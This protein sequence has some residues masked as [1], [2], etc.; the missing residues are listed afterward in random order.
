MKNRDSQL[1]RVLEVYEATVWRF[2]ERSRRLWAAAE[3]RALGYGGVTLVREAT[4]FSRTTITQGLHE[5][6]ELAED[7]SG[8]AFW[9]GRIR[10][11]GSGRKRATEH[12]PTLLE[13]LEKLVDPLTRGDPESALRWTSKSHERLAEELRAMGHCNH[14]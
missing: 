6:D 1:R 10:A 12:D 13:D 9:K 8:E 2:D 11:P 3:S 7:P 14:L 5:L 4:G